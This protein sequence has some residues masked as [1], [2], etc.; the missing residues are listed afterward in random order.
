MIF[1]DTWGF[2]TFI[3]RR[4]HKHHE[5]KKL[6]IDNWNQNVEFFTSD[7][8][9]DETITHI[10]NKLDYDKL[11]KFINATDGAISSGFIRLLW[12][13]K[14]D[15]EAAKDLK[16]KYK[17]KL[18]ISFTD[19]T[20]AVLMKKYNI[21]DIITEDDHFTQIGMGFNKLF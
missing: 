11:K 2:K 12:V 13:S 14:D 16:L 21:I 17:D 1:I 20:S 3:D 10:S 6:F 9:I 18:K 4:E 19:M 5:V 7:Y 8:I 15:F